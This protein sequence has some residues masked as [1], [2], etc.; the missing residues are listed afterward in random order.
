[1]VPSDNSDD[2]QFL[3]LRAPGS[4]SPLQS[5]HFGLLLDCRA[6]ISHPIGP[7]RKPKI[8][9]N[10]CFP[11]LL[12]MRAPTAQ[13]IAHQRSKTCMKSIIYPVALL[14]QQYSDRYNKNFLADRFYTVGIVLM[15]VDGCQPVLTGGDICTN[16]V[17][18]PNSCPTSHCAQTPVTQ[19]HKKDSPNAKKA[20]VYG[21][22]V[23]IGDSC[24]P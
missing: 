11:L 13:H 8:P 22:S 4:T 20:N 15:V 18:M 23:N 19:Q 6:M 10:A 7:K 2:P 9:P 5:L 24:A 1:M 3:H 14:T 16:C 21:T 12:P 17:P